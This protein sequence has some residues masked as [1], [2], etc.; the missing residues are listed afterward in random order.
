[1]LPLIQLSEDEFCDTYA[2]ETDANGDLYRQRNHY[3]EVD[4]GLILDAHREHRLWTVIEGVEGEYKTW[5]VVSGYHRVNRLYHIIT[6]HP[7]DPT[8]EFEVAWPW[9]DDPREGDSAR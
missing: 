7:Y 5:Y 1:M 9:I 3:E 6:A 4:R 2:P 8:V